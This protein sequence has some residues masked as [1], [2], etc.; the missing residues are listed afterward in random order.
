MALDRDRLKSLV[1]I[2]ESRSAQSFSTLPV[3]QSER[4][5]LML[6]HSKCMAVFADRGGCDVPD[7]GSAH[8][9]AGKEAIELLCQ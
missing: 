3:T 8:L 7:V 9:K 1:K 4:T 6:L 5:E 2:S